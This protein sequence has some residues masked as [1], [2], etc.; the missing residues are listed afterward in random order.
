[1][2]FGNTIVEL[3]SR[4]DLKAWDMEQRDIL[5]KMIRHRIL[6]K[7][8]PRFI[9]R[10]MTFAKFFA[11]YFNTHGETPSVKEAENFMKAVQ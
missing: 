2:N 1:M 8:D 5:T 6:N 10:V 9:D 7:T 4:E 3:A 11:D